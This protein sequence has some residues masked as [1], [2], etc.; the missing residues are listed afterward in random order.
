MKMKEKAIYILLLL[1]AMTLGAK[2]QNTISVA[3]LTGGQG[4][5]VMIPISMDNNEDVV[6]LQFDLQLPFA[7]TSGKQPTLTNRNT[8]GHTVSVRG[9]GSNRYRVVIVNM[10]NKPIA[11][12]GG[13]LLNFPMTVPTGLDPES[14]H[15]ITLSDVVITNRNGDNIQTGS[16]NGSYTIQRAPSP[17]LEVSDVAIRQTTLTPGERVSVSWKVS[18]VGNADTRSGWTEKVYLVNT[19][20][21]EAVY[22]GNVYFNNTML[23]GGH[24]AR[25]AEFVLSQTVGVDGEV[26]AKVVV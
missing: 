13:V 18:N 4:K 9:M 8:N 11:G 21:E 14:V 3:H 1:V 23:Q 20:T 25:S 2:A 7:K 10:S 17:D 19:E 24:T 22:I 6:A 15:A 12:S 5:D 16:T 26:A